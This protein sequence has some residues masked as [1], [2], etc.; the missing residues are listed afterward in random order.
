M[1]TVVS[2]LFTTPN[3]LAREHGER[4]FWQARGQEY[5][6]K[7]FA[8]ARRHIHEP[9]RA[10]LLTDTGW[11]PDGVEALPLHP[12]PNVTTGWWAKLQVFAG[13]FDRADVFYSDLDNVIAG[14]LT[15]ILSL[16]PDP[17]W[18]LDDIVH[19]RRVNLAA[20]YARPRRLKGLWERYLEDPAG[21]RARY[22]VWP[23]ASDQAFVWDECAR[24]GIDL[25]SCFLQEWVGPN[26]ILNSRAELEQ[27]ADWSDVRLV[28][29]S[30][31]PKPHASTHPFYAEH[32][33][34]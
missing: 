13:A 22:R 28:Y 18:V 17:L 23:H 14:D 29:G 27:G 33:R 16:D 12:D 1:L 32:W 25:T 20:F 19:P 4:P 21:T 5:A 7:F 10:V 34:A 31:D 6:E 8:G 2:M 11:A 3:P 26:Q 15:P 30:W 9:F 24:V